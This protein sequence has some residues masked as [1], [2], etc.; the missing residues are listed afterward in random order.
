MPSAKQSVTNKH[1]VASEIREDIGS[2]KTRA[3]GDKSS[4]ILVNEMGFM[5]LCISPLGKIHFKSLWVFAGPD[6]AVKKRSGV[7]FEWLVGLVFVIC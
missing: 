2:V 6:S 7:V 3:M 1:A 5:Y 4:A